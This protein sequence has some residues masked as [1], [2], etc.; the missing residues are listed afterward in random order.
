MAYSKHDE[1][2]SEAASRGVMSDSCFKKINQA[3]GE[4]GVWGL[5]TKAG[6]QDA[7]SHDPGQRLGWLNLEEVGE[8]DR[9]GQ[10]ELWYVYLLK[11][12]HSIAF[13]S[14]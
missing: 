9:N 1:K 8:T 4:R 11:W 10:M 5:R 7:S 2:L 12:G 3:A 13:S 14:S 6:R